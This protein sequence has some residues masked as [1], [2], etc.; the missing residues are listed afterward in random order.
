MWEMTPAIRLKRTKTDPQF[1]NA[2]SSQSRSHFVGHFVAHLFGALVFNP[3]SKI[4]IP[5]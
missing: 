1:I 3:K 5:K 2:M 4:K